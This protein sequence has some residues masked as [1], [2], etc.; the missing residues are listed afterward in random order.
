[1]TNSVS[2][3]ADLNLWQLKV[4]TAEK[5]PELVRVFLKEHKVSQAQP[6]FTLQTCLLHGTLRARNIGD[7]LNLPARRDKPAE[8][9]FVAKER[10]TSQ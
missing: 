1:M 6:A 10:L 3:F 4:K 2:Y 5:S 7:G 8:K 9:I